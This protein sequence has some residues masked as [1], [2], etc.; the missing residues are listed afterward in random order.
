[1]LNTMYLW[2]SI[3][4]FVLVIAFLFGSMLAFKHGFTRTAN[5]V[6]ERVISALSAEINALHDEIKTL[7][8]RLDELESDKIRLRM[9]INAIVSAMKRRRISIDIQQDFINIHDEQSG[10]SDTVQI[11]RITE[12][13]L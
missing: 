3:L 9:I 8:E 2:F 1:M 11:T 13:Q 10:K 4:N 7:K 6:Q 5:E 12:Q